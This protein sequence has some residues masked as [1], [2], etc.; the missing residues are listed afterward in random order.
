MPIVILRICS[1]NYTFLFGMALEVDYLFL[2]KILDYDDY[3]KWRFRK[4][5]HKKT[6]Q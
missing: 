4:T 2:H 5:P 1:F 6:R 3:T